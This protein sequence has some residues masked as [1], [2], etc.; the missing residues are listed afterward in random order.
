MNNNRRSSLICAIIIYCFQQLPRIVQALK[1][2]PSLSRGLVNERSVMVPNSLVEVLRSAP[3]VAWSRG[4]KPAFCTQWSLLD[5]FLKYT[6]QSVRHSLC[7]Q[8]LLA[9]KADRHAVGCARSNCK[10]CCVVS[11]KLACE[12]S[13]A[14][15]AEKPRCNQVTQRLYSSCRN[16]LGLA[17]TARCL[18]RPNED[19]GI[20]NQRFLGTWHVLGAVAGVEAGVDARLRTIQGDKST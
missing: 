10:S 1:V 7:S 13:S 12:R 9:K 4:P 19:L 16:T 8:L 2:L 18:N 17:S 5:V 3:C 14:Q 15:S 6:T 11:D 20:I